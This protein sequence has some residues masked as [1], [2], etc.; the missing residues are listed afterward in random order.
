M[1]LSTWL[2]IFIVIRWVYVEIMYKEAV[3]AITELTEWHNRNQG[4]R[5]GQ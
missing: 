4:R 2:F 1:S 5:V 3:K